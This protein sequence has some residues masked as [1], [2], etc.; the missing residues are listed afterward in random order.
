M[1]Q[2]HDRT[3]PEG[4]IVFLRHR[5]TWPALKSA[6][7]LVFFVPGSRNRHGRPYQKLQALKESKLSI[8]FPYKRSNNL[9]FHEHT[10]S[11][12]HLTYLFC[13]QFF[14]TLTLLPGAAAPLS[15][16]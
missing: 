16:P 11:G 4:N 5:S 1:F 7:Q 6:T 15:L 8:E 10:K 2:R 14:S 9:K 3:S 13:R 12:F